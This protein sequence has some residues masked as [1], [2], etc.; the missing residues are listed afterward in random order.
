M[1]T[2]LARRPGPPEDVVYRAAAILPGGGRAAATGLHVRGDSI[3]AI[4]DAD[5]LVQA[6]PW[7][8][9]VDMAGATIV[10]GLIDAHCH[11][12]MLAYLLT[13]ADCTPAAAPDVATIKE[14]L[15][16]TAAGPEGWVTGSG[17]AEYQLTDR[18]QPTRWDLDEAVPETP[19][20]LYHRSLHL[21]IVNSAGLRALGYTDDTPDPP[22]GW[23]GRDGQGRLD[24]RLIEGL[25]LDLINA[26]MGR[27]FE[28]L[29]AAGRSAVIARAG[30]HLASLGITACADA[31]ADAGA[32]RALREAERRGELPVR[33]NVMFTYAEAAWLLR[34]GMTTAYGSDRLRVGAIKLFADGGMSSRTAAVD[35]PYLEPPGEMGLLWYETDALASI[36]RDCQDAGFQ[37]GIHAQGERGIRMVL[38]AYGAVIEP[39][40]PLRHRI[41]HGGMFAPALRAVAARRNIH[42]VSQPGF[43][44]PLGDGY[45][46]AFGLARTQG[47]YPFASLLREGVL[48][49]GSSDAPVISASPL[50]GMRDAMVR[51]SE[52]GASIGLDEA[53]T[54][55]EALELY[56]GAAAFVGWQDDRQGSLEPGKLADFTVLDRN[57]LTVT[58]AE[59][60]EAAVMLTVVGGRTVFDGR[61][62]VAAGRESS[63]A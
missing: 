50:L 27:Q 3:V 42:V 61:V 31:A 48:V 6:A 8:R 13:G 4:G 34:A 59:L 39:G 52:S 57:P 7:A 9:V 32:F 16:A 17:Y 5:G 37:V 15:A 45:V 19:C 43:L 62:A 1:A 54:A 58:A 49:A 35:E 20:I 24:G 28:A 14:R 33:V 29:D 10:P 36:I 26:N 2:E 30:L 23:L 22:R 38:D 51:R 44:A 55:E 40:N 25:T 63:R 56:T 46:E 53:L 18:R 12:T 41:E 47:L 60:G 21:A 11:V